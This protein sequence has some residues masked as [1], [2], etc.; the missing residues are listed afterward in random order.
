[1]KVGQI[2]EIAFFIPKLGKLDPLTKV[3][4]DYVTV[5]ASYWN[6]SEI[7]RM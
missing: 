7:S 5:M 2:S 6:I 1:M 4:S 3:S